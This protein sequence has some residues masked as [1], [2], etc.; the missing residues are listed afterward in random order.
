MDLSG[1]PEPGAQ[2]S[3]ARLRH[4]AWARKLL[5]HFSLSCSLQAREAASSEGARNN[6]EMAQVAGEKQLRITGCAQ[7]L[8]SHLARQ[9]QSWHRAPRSF[10]S[11]T[12][13][14]RGGL[15][16]LPPPAQS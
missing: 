13:F 2:A 6:W 7:A 1:R 15:P 14:R 5:N 9:G 12:C 4:S 3:R 10:T 16:L 8:R 11:F